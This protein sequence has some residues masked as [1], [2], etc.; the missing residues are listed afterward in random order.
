MMTLD[1]LDW[2][3]SLLFDDRPYADLTTEGLG[4]GAAR[5]RIDA[6]L[7]APGVAAGVGIA[8]ALFRRAGAE[9]EVFLEDGARLEAGETILRAEGCAASLH[10][11]Y[12]TAQCVLEYAGG[13]AART[14]I[15]VERAQAVRPAVLIAGTRKH[16]PGGKRIALAGLAAGGGIVH[17]LGLSDSIL[18]FD[19]HRVFCGDF[20]AAFARLKAASPERKV[21]VEAASPEEGLAFVRMGA[22]IVQCERFTPAALA[23]FIAAARALNPALVVS[24]A[25][26]VKGENAADYARAGADILVTSWP[27]WAPPQDVKMGF[28]RIEGGR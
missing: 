14:R 6:A 10:A 1:P 2:I 20:A 13:I 18:V 9:V 8:A 25:G 5:G 4:I 7:K 27:Y 3:D 17:R 28:S 15:M 26:G 16:W 24:A 19:Q 11:V 22:D 12:K 23:E 21:A